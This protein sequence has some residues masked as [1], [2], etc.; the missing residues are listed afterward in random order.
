MKQVNK[1]LLAVLM[2]LGLATA[3]GAQPQKAM[4]KAVIKL[5]TMNPKCEKAKETIENALW[6]RVDGI[7]AIDVRV[8]QKICKVTYVPDR[9]DLDNIR[10]RIAELG[11]DADGE[12]ADPEAAKKLMGDCMPIAP[13]AVAA[14]PPPP[15]PPPPL[16]DTSRKVIAKPAPKPVKAPPK[17]KG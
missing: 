11:F 16:V 10:I 13:P 8:K 3:A 4:V 9:I 17:K 14:P 15:P 5:P 1:T 6:K 2:V 12:K 7:A